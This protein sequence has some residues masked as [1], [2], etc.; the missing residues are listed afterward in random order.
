MRVLVVGASGLLGSNV[1]SIAI[2]QGQTV[3]GSYYSKEPRLDCPSYCMD[4]ASQ[5]DVDNLVQQTTPDVIINCAAM[6]DVDQCER[7]PDQAYAI[8]MQ[9]AENLARA[10]REVDAKLV[11][12][13]TDYIFD[14]RRKSPYPERVDP[15]PLQV[16]GKSKLDGERKVR[17]MISNLLILRLS[18]V[19]GYSFADQSMSGFPAWVYNKIQDGESISLFTDQSVT[20]SYAKATAMTI[21]NLIERNTSGTYNVASQSC[22]TPYEFGKLIAKEAGSEST[23]INKG[24]MEDINR[25][26]KRPHYTCLDTEA[27]K[28]TLGRAQPTLSDSVSDL[29]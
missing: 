25:D 19:Y 5:S 18:F 10:A 28:K 9:G 15:N 1:A 12:I 13:S 11:H 16:Y 21:L 6:T 2:N 17:N 23:L 29:F 7:E 8:N 3:I 24:S 20:P 26:A 22:V 4:I 14:G 27:I